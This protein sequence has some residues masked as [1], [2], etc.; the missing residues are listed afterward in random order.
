MKKFDIE[1]SVGLFISVGLLCIVYTSIQ[2]GQVDIFNQK[3]YY[4]IKAIFSSVT[5]LK[6]DTNVEIAGVKVGT[7]KNIELENYQATVSMSIRKN[8]EIQEDA[9]A[10][11]RT[12]GLLGEKYIAITPGAS[13]DLIGSNGTIFDT[14]PPFDLEGVIKHFVVDDE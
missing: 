3:N 12:K 7:I 6:K 10:S 9:I 2:L 13:D 8:I 14:E 1:L 5:G 4:P 11:I